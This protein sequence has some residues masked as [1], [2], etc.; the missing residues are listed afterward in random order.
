[1]RP[2]YL[3]PPYLLTCNGLAPSAPEESQASHKAGRI[4]CVAKY[5]RR[6]Y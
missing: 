5:N 3:T 6:I 1:M 2:V 4:R